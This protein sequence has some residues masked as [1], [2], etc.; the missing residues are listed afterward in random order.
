MRF[1]IPKNGLIGWE[2]YVC[3][4]RI[5]SSDSGFPESNYWNVKL[6]EVYCSPEHSLKRH[7]QLSK[8]YINPLFCY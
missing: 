7:K 4:A 1:N 6:K 5:K 8:E 3:G 2:C